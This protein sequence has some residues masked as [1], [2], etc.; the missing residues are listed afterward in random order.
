[1]IGLRNQRSLV[2]ILSGAPFIPQYFHPKVSGGGYRL[3]NFQDAQVQIFTALLNW[4]LPSGL[5]FYFRYTPNRTRFHL[6]ARGAWN[7][8]GRTR[9]VWDASRVFSPYISFGLG[10]ESFTGVSTEQLG[11]F[12]AQTYG[13]GTEVRFHSAQ[14]FRVGYYF[15]NR[16]RG[17]REQ[18]VSASYLFSF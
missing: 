17:R 9:L 18:G 10:A 3:L 8:G 7:Q 11:R 15:Q 1:M 2:R 5:H 4:Q 14:G 16:T 12:S 6:T 13:A